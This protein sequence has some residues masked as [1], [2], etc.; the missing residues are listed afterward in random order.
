MFSSNVFSYVNVL[1]KAADASWLREET[2]AN[3][4][5]NVNTPGYKRKDV[6]FQS[7][8]RNE[9]G[10]MKYQTLDSKVEHA[11]LSR[12]DASV[13]VDS[14]NYSYRIDKNNVDVD[15]ENV[16]L[17]SEK[18][19]YDALTDSMTQEFARLKSVMQ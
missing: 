12:L 6:D 3:N 2:I 1:N 11:D 18:L 4:L 5:A 7:V 19:R 8:L 17:A 14:A 10:N 13:Y 9:L 16:E 15:V